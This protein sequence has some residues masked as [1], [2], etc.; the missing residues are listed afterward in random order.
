MIDMI[1]KIL[2]IANV[3]LPIAFAVIRKPKIFYSKIIILEIN[4][5]K[6]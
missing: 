4:F 6:C 2:L 3:I 1:D 5:K